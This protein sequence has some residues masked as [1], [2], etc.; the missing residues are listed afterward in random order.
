MIRLSNR[1]W[2]DK[3]NVRLKYT[4]AGSYIDDEAFYQTMSSEAVKSMVGKDTQCD[5]TMGVYLW[6]GKGLLRVASARWEVLSFTPRTNCRDWM[7]VFAHGSIFTSPAI[8]LMCRDR[9]GLDGDDLLFVDE[10]LAGV[11]NDKFQMAVHEMADIK[12]E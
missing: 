3:R 11:P 5:G 1:F 4:A 2:K 12:R 10:W 8:N 7:L 9:V 6:Q